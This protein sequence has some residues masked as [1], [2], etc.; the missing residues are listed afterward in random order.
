MWALSLIDHKI[1][2]S[3]AGGGASEKSHHAKRI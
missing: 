3:E 2:G 1:N